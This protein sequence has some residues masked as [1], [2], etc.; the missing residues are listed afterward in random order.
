MRSST[1]WPHS[2]RLPRQYV[3]IVDFYKKV[4]NT[5]FLI[6]KGREYRDRLS[7][8]QEAESTL[9]SALGRTPTEEETKARA[10]QICQMK[11]KARAKADW[12]EATNIVGDRF[13]IIPVSSIREEAFDIYK[14]RSKFRIPGTPQDDWMHAEQKFLK[15]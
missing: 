10:Q 15:C 8:W 4:E 5:A 12:F 14:I 2:S 11:R 3:T 6:F 13:A 9:Y 7:D 1:T